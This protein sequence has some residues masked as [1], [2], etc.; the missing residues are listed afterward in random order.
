MLDDVRWHEVYEQNDFDLATTMFLEK[1]RIKYNEAIPS[2][3]CIKPKSK[4]CSWF[5]A[6]LRSLQKEK[7]TA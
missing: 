6:E 3:T 5:D 7:W 4:I 2:I 1:L